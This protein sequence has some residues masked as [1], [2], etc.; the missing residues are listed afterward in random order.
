MNKKY[1]VTIRIENS[2][3]RIECEKK[4]IPLENLRLYLEQ[5]HF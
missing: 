3:F 2:G 1:L 4:F 5:L